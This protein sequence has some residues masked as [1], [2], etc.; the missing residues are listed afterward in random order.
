MDRFPPGALSRAPRDG[1]LSALG[2][3][4][5]ALICPHLRGHRRRGARS[6]TFRGS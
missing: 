3:V 1:L 4:P 5:V 6:G 2:L